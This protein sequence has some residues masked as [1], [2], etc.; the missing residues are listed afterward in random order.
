MRTSKISSRLRGL[1][2][3]GRDVLLAAEAV[4]VLGLDVDDELELVGHAALRRAVDDVDR[5]L[6]LDLWRVRGAR[7]IQLFLML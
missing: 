3:G 6:A 2:G 5:D 1:A 7:G 4:V